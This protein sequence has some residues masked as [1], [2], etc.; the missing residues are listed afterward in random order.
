MF[1]NY[2]AAALRNLARNW[3][4]AGITI[5]GLAVAFAAGILIVLFIRDEH[6]YERFIPGHEAVLRLDAVQRAPGAA[7]QPTDRS[8]TS[9]ATLL[10]LDFSQIA[11]I[12]RISPRRRGCA[13]ISSRLPI[14]S[15][16]PTP[17]CSAF[18]R[19]RLSPAISRRRCNRPTQWLL[20]RSMARKYFGADA[21]V[22]QI[23]EVNPA[24]GNLP[25]LSAGRSAIARQLPPMRVTAV[26]EDLP[27][28]THLDGEIFAAAIAPF[29]PMRRW[30]ALPDS[31]EV[32]T[33]L[34]QQPGASAADIVREL[35]AFSA[36][37][38]GPAAQ[39]QVSWDL[40]LTPLDDIH[41]AP[42][43]GGSLKPRGDRA[44]DA[45]VAAVGVL[46][47]LI[48]A[49]NFVTL[50]TARA[51][52]R[53][54]E[55]GVR[56]AAVRTALGPRAA[57]HRRSADLRGNGDDRG[58]RAGGDHPAVRRCVPAAGSAPRLS[59][60]RDARTGWRWA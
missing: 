26:I 52:R 27:S 22:G 11:A 59:A 49:I 45:G 20:T 10:K 33:Y 18:C 40:H 44:V 58:V 48:A 35:P 25:G 28:N 2:L 17:R 41:L 46:I 34:R 5:F 13:V 38:F 47:V 32:H 43:A 21:P 14:R 9:V 16:G 24:L 53:A 29:S 60:R 12:A 6:S 50:M 8:P 23:L 1:R 15:R 56:K 36:R 42:P 37:H 7:P 19:W 3:Q 51:T 31:V 30:E 39:T 54:V 55:V 4:H 57:V